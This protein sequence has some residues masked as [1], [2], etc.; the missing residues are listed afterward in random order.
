MKRNPEDIERAARF[1]KVLAHPA[2]LEIACRLAEGGAS[3]KHLIAE[4]GWPQSSVAR[5]LAPLRD[6]GIVQG[7]RKGSE[8]TLSVGSPIIQQLVQSVCEWLHEEGPAAGSP[9]RRASSH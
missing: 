6:S 2:R 8:V 7:E 1:F 4:L 9:T 3:Q 5:F